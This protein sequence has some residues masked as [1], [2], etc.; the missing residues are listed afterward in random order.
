MAGHLRRLAASYC[1]KVAD[2]R[3]LKEEC[4]SD[5]VKCLQLLSTLQRNVTYFYT[6]HL[7]ALFSV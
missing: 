5:D 4:Y 2:L 1:L 7:L 6:L 3:L